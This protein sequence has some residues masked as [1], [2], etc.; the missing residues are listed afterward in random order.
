[1]SDIELTARQQQIAAL[2]IQGMSNKEIAR[3]L[4]VAEGTIK[5]HLHVLYERLNVTSRAKLVAKLQRYRT[6]GSP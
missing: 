3:A 5:N 1:M 6:M 2:L 4:A